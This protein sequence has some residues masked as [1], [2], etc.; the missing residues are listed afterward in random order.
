MIILTMTTIFMHV[1]VE[2]AVFARSGARAAR[3][4]QRGLGGFAAMCVSIARC[5]IHLLMYLLIL[6][7]Y[8]IVILGDSIK[9]TMYVIGIYVHYNYSLRCVLTNIP[10]IVVL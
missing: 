6:D 3:G 10:T 4:D 2:E 5:I 8:S 9:P 1:Y 7:H